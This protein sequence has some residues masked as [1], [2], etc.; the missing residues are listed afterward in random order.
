M[1]EANN[2]V[3]MMLEGLAQSVCEVCHTVA[4][5]SQEFRA[6][7]MEQSQTQANGREFKIPGAA[8]PTFWG[9]PSENFDGYVFGAKVYMRGCNIDYTR[10]ENQPRV[11]AIMCSGLRGGAASFLTHRLMIDNLPIRD[12]DE[13]ESV[14]SEEFVPSDQQQ[15]LRA[16]LRACRQS[17]AIED[18]VARFREIIM[19][20]RQMSQLDQVDHFIAGFKPET[21]KEVNYLNCETLRDAIAAAQAYERAHF[22][23]AAPRRPRTARL[24]DAEPM[25]V[26][27]VTAPV[28]DETL[29]VAQFA[30]RPARPSMEACRRQGLC[31][32]CREAGHRISVCPRKKQG[33]GHAQRM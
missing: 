22:G 13:F 24:Q 20:I 29:D 15:R 10:A 1:E 30:S 31:F 16:A 8:M 32:Y 26:S 23:G 14:F 11:V 19:Q 18:Y 4:N 6:I 17:G 5:Q 25:D 9:K 33:N 2:P 21:Q 7:F 28:G 27:Y 12:L 3:F